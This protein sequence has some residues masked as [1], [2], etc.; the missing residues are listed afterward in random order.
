MLGSLQQFAVALVGAVGVFLLGKL[1]IAGGHRAFEP[2]LA[3]IRPVLLRIDHALA[4]PLARWIGLDE[5]RAWRRWSRLLGT[6]CALGFVGAVAPWPLGVIALSL[7]LLAVLAVFRRWAWDENDRELGLPSEDR[8]FRNGEDYGDEAL[9]AL[10]AVVMLSSLL[11]WRLTGVHAFEGPVAEGE[12]GYLLHILSETLAALPIIGNVDVLGYEDPSGVRVLQPNGGP[13]AFALRMAI[14][15]VVIG[16]LLKAVDIARRMARGQDLRREEEAL[17]SRDLARVLPS[18]HRLRRLAVGG[19]ANAMNLLASAAASPAAGQAPRARLCAVHALR[20]AAEQHPEWAGTILLDN[21]LACAAVLAD[22]ATADADLLGAAHLENA[23]N[24]LAEARMSQDHV[25]AKLIGSAIAGLSQAVMAQGLTPLPEAFLL[26]RPPQTSMPARSALV[27]RLAELKL[28]LTEH[29]HTDSAAEILQEALGHVQTVL[30]HLPAEATPDARLRVHQ[31]HAQILARL[32]ERDPSYE[33]SVLLTD[34]LDAFAHA[35]T[36]V[37]DGDALARIGLWTGRG[38]VHEILGHRTEGPPSVAHFAEAA[39]LFDAAATLMVDAQVGTADAAQCFINLGNA[40]GAAAQ[41]TESVAIDDDQA[42]PVQA[43]L[44]R[45]V[46]AYSNGL[47]LVGAGHW[48]GLA[49]NAFHGLAAAHEHRFSRMG[50]RH[51]IE[52]AIGARL[53]ILDEIDP[54]QAPAEWARAAIELSQAEHL[55][56][57]SS[58]S[59]SI[60]HSAV[61]R[62]RQARERLAQAGDEEALQRCDA[63]MEAIRADV[64]ARDRG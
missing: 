7:G 40:C 58:A 2:A 24:A 20:S 1:L 18:I 37:D 57:P 41:A 43:W 47:R 51:D 12:P 36:L 11:V 49:H 4:M 27:L 21:R 19:D 59:T 22:P 35:Q 26:D 53:S 13:V 32:G 33:G 64:A 23:E 62:L 52:A 45:A 38:V 28:R 60:G 50:E 3:W 9:A 63:L 48:P 54:R 5:N 56:L 55:A 31:C 15:L 25:A 61:D 17:A 34:A 14:D 39:Q 42:T 29:V 46:Q 10:A 30:A 44:D 6:L 16:G 8:R